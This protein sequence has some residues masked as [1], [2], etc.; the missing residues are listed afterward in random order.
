MDFLKRESPPIHPDPQ[1]MIDKIART[2]IRVIS[3]VRAALKPLQF[4]LKAFDYRVGF[5]AQALH[6]LQVTAQ[7]TDD[8]RIQ[9]VIR[10]IADAMDQPG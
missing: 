2:G 9:I 7:Q 5:F 8:I 1:T 6:L 4:R 10:R 3:V